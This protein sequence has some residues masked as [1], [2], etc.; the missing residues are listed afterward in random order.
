MVNSAGTSDS[1]AEIKRQ[2]FCPQTPG[3]AIIPTK[4][5]EEMAL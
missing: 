3:Q 1:T 4:H 5:A 2:H